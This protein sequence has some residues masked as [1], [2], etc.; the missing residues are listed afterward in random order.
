VNQVTSKGPGM[1]GSDSDERAGGRRTASA[2]TSADS[3][4]SSG[5]HMASIQATCGA[6]SRGARPSSRCRN[7]PSLT[8]SPTAPTSP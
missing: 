3:T 2:A 7:P 8:S 6:G 4:A 5:R 1:S